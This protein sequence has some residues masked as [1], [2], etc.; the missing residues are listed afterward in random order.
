MSRMAN[1]QLSTPDIVR[2]NTMSWEDLRFGISEKIP[3]MS[4]KGLRGIALEAWQSVHIV[5]ALYRMTWMWREHDR[6]IRWD[7]DRLCR[8][9]PWQDQ[10]IL[11]AQG[12]YLHENVGSWPRTDVFIN[13]SASACEDVII[14]EFATP[15]ATAPISK[16]LIHATTFEPAQFPWSKKQ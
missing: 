1:R 9:T 7:R 5:Y 10:A 8:A 3:L 13:S 4:C 6:Y 2:Q 14:P 16:V 11:E 15:S 12:G